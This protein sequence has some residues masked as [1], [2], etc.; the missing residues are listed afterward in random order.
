M[1]AFKE[2]EIEKDEAVLAIRKA[3]S[4]IIEAAE[5]LKASRID[6]IATNGALIAG[7]DHV[8]AC[9]ENDAAL[10]NKLADIQEDAEP[11][12]RKLV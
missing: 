4:A 11:A 3:A 12:L 9:L 6:I 10:L 7:V 8:T 1:G 2:L 5:T